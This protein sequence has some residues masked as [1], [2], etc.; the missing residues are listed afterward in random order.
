MIAVSNPSAHSGTLITLGWWYRLDAQFARI[1]RLSEAQIESLASA[2][3]GE[4]PI[5]TMRKLIP[6]LAALA[7]P[8]A[9]F[10]DIFRRDPETL[11]PFIATV[12][13]VDALIGQFERTIAANNNETSNSDHEP[14]P[15]NE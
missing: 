14:E 2:V 13:E 9:V 8:G 11:E 1:K 5:D 4:T 10:E 12:L 15:E 3:D 6:C 7:N